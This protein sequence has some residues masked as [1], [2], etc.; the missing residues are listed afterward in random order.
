MTLRDII[1]RA[2]AVR[3]DRPLGS[4]HPQYGF[5]YPVNYGYVPDTPASDGNDLD[6]Y[7]LGV[8]DPIESFTGRCIAM[9]HRLDDDDDKLIFVP[10]G[11]QFSDEQIQALAEFQERFFTSIIQR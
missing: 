11:R 10:E 9:V 3:I 8:F 4:R 6:A 1:N 2:V 7:V 5:I